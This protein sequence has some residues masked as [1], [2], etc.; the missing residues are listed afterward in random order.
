MLRILFYFIAFSITLFAQSP[1][2]FLKFNHSARGTALAGASASLEN[3]ISLISYNPAL[4]QT[5]EENFVN[6]TFMKNVLDINSGNASFIYDGWD[7]GKVAFSAH[8]N[9]WGSFDRSDALGNV[10]GTF[11]G[12]DLS[13]GAFVSNELDSNFYYGIGIK[14]IFSG[15]DDVSGSALAVDAGLFYR[16]NERTNLGASILNAGA[17]ISQFNGENV[18]LPLDI[19]ISANHRLRGLP[20]VFNAALHS[21]ADDL[22]IGEKLQ[23][24]S[25][26]LEINFGQYLRAR[27]GYNNLVREETSVDFD[28][29]I[30]GF[31]FGGG[32]VFNAARL[33]Y[34]LATYGTQTSQHRISLLFDL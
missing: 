22:T 16:I 4:I 23:N 27:V 11:G 6:V 5:V 17:Q 18:N 33:D 24:I 29:G 28:P 1:Y 8:F 2:G 13:I 20:L 14:Y 25:V 10:N 12:S 32:L 15:I 26:G 9:D 3:D 21:L 34:S 19:R 30:S 31:T 7:F